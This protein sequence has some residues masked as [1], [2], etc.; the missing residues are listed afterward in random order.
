MDVFMS[1]QNVKETWLSWQS[2]KHTKWNILISWHA[3]IN[4]LVEKRANLQWFQYQNS[5]HYKNLWGSIEGSRTISVD[6]CLDATLL[7][8]RSTRT[9]EIMEL[10]S[11]LW[12]ARKQRF[13]VKI[14]VINAFACPHNFH[15]FLVDETLMIFKTRTS[16]LQHISYLQLHRWHPRLVRSS[17]H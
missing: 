3:E 11:S 14:S 5:F 13:R 8:Y 7:R 6:H 4:K 1:C 10:Q 9:E 12:G 15:T 2:F 17:V 16:W